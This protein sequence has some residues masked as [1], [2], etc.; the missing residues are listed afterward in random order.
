MQISFYQKGLRLSEAQEDYIKSKLESLTK[1]KVLEDPSV[2]VRIDVEYKEHIS[3]EKKVFMAVTAVV[4]HDTLRVEIDALTVE[5]GMDLLE[6]KL[7]SQLEKY[8]TV[9]E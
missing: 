6:P 4:P 8:K 2:T 5:E 3:S 7:R 9:R 1:F